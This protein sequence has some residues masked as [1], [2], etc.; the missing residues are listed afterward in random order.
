MASV[1][2]KEY[3]MTAVEIAVKALIELSNDKSADA[4]VRC[5]A[6]SNLLARNIDGELVFAGY[7]ESGQKVAA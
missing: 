4:S 2:Q 7:D 5:S 6:A 3:R 1:Q